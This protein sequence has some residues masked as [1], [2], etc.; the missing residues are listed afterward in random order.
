MK[1]TIWTVI[2][3]LMLVAGCAE[4]NPFV[5]D[6][7]AQWQGSADLPRLAGYGTLTGGLGTYSFTD[8]DRTLEGIQDGIMLRFDEP[9]D[10]TTI[11]D[12]SFELV[13][14]SP[15]PG[16][17]EL[18]TILYFPGENTAIL[19]GTFAEET[20]YMLTISAGAV[21][22]LG[23]NALDAN[24]N[25]LFDGA[26]LDD[27]RLTF[28]TGSAQ[29]AD[30][31]SP[32]IT[33]SWP[34]GGGVESLQPEI[35]LVFSDGPMEQS[36]LNLDNLTLVRTSDQSPVELRVTVLED[37]RIYCT[38]VEPL[39]NGTRYTI[40]M[41]A[42]ITD[43]AGNLFDTNNDGW[44]WPGEPDRTWDFQTVDN[45][46]THGTPP[47]V[48]SATLDGDVVLIEFV[49]SLTGR[50]V[51]MDPATF[52]A[53]NIQCMDDSGGIP[54]SFQPRLGGAGVVC[55]PQREIVGPMTVHVSCNVAD[56][57]GNLLDGNNNGLGGTPGEDDWSGTPGV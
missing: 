23:G 18:T 44:I 36:H 55:L 2:A 49:Q 3:A 35:A 28:F 38:P 41:V 27:Q 19:R 53:A 47:T 57:Y 4:D 40:T 56:Q 5:A 12:A 15:V 17:V 11:T 26:P 14:T 6:P 25:E 46:T 50:S 8:M 51:V 24:H 54:L 32:S 9:M 13:M 7:D 42:G 34:Q 29:M 52:I 37:D 20:A 33:A 1:K 21:T 39:A 45:D 10:S 31:T 48:L 16:P 30:I 43:T 22:D